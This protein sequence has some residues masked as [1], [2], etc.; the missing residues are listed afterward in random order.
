VAKPLNQYPPESLK[1]DEFGNKYYYDEQQK[2]KV[3]EINGEPVVVLDE[4]ILSIN[5]DSI[6]SWIRITIIF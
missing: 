5:R 2:I 1:V 6:I 4:L 3:Y